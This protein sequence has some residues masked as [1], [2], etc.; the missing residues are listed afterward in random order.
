M[1]RKL[2][3]WPFTGFWALTTL[4]L[5]RCR[6]ACGLSEVS[7]AFWWDTASAVQAFAFQGTHS[8]AWWVGTAFISELILLGLFAGLLWLGGFNPGRKYPLWIAWPKYVALC[9]AACLT[10]LMLYR[11]AF[12]AGSGVY[13]LALQTNQGHAGIML[14]SQAPHLVLQILAFSVVWAAP[15]FW[16]VRGLG[17]RSLPRATFESWV[18]VRR[19]LLPGVLLLAASAAVEGYLT[20]LLTNW[21]LR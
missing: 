9:A 5:M 20:P 4:Q 11:K 15:L 7:G 19:L 21:F 13:L 18:E 10:G 1:Y 8:V 17:V 12:L 6:T 16:L 14:V 3:L 2:M